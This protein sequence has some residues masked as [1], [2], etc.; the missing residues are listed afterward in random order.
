MRRSWRWIPL[1][2]AGVIGASCGTAN[3]DGEGYSGA[4]AVAL[5]QEDVPA[6]VRRGLPGPGHAILEALEGTWRVE[7]SLYIA[8]GTRDEPAE[9]DD[10][11]CRRVW[12]AD[13]RYLRDVTE[14]T[15]AG[16]PYWRL[17]LLG[18]STMDRRYE[19]V[20]IDMANANMMIYRGAPGSGEQ[21]P[22][23]MS[24]TFTDQGVMGEATVGKPIDQRTVIRIENDDRHIVDL[25][26]TPPGDEEILAD[27][28]V[29]T[30]V[31][32][33]A[34]RGAANER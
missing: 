31:Q 23:T 20:T 28:S 26:F 17:G 10:L 6:W 16:V 22:I 5:P 4:P 3:G 11:T 29:Y 18:Y 24:G 34:R 2:L 1:V 33:P 27:R 32:D 9:S 12:L 30:R 14:G 15:I 25:Y 19:W 21:V 13:G 8:L 7:K